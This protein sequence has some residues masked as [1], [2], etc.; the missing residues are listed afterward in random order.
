ML[1][2]ARMRNKA[3]GRWIAEALKMMTTS[4]RVAA[5]VAKRWLMRLPDRSIEV[6]RWL[7]RL[8]AARCQHCE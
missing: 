4:S 7:L 3:R 8:L 5:D 1:F 6:K 2:A